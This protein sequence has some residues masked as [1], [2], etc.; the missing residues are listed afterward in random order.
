VTVAGV[1]VA[2]TTSQTEVIGSQVPR[3]VAHAAGVTMPGTGAASAR[4]GAI[5]ASPTQPASTTAAPRPPFLPLMWLLVPHLV[6][7]TLTYGA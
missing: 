7:P 2:T 3:T 5:T 6:L 1:P 4:P